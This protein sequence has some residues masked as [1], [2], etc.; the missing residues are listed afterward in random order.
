MNNLIFILLSI[1]LISGQIIKVP[2]I[3]KSGLILLDLTA[4]VSI[5]ILLFKSKFK[6][7]KPPLFLIFGVIFCLLGIVSVFI[8]PANLT[9]NDK[10]LSISYALRILI[11]LSLGYLIYNQNTKA[12]K[13]KIISL[14]L[15]SGVALAVIGLLQFIFLPNLLFLNEEGWDPHYFRTVSTLLDPN[16]AGAFFILTLATI[17]L[18]LKGKKSYILLSIVFVALLTTF[19][20]GAYLMFFVT[21]ISLSILTKSI[22]TFAITFLLGLI[23]Y[24]GFLSYTNIIAVPRNINR[25]QSAQLRVSSWSMGWELFQKSPIFGVGLNSYRYALRNFNI[26]PLSFIQSRGGSSNDSSLL[27]A[28]ATTGLIGFIF[29]SLFLITVFKKS[30]T[31][32]KQSILMFAGLLGL[33]VESFFANS[34]FYPHFLLWIILNGILLDVSKDS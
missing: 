9:I 16:F 24:L 1:G 15:V 18:N 6:F 27:H 13:Q 26:A 17:Y 30:L 33:V 19:S 22:K 29:Y 21:F 31:G 12:L 3:E 2:L 14:F 34:L 32:G 4:L 5:F 28:L 11:Y 23:I 20:R 25:T 8:S 10:L 7:I